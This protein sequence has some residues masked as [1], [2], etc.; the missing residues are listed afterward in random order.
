MLYLLHSGK[1]DILTDDNEAEI[2]AR[3]KSEK[4]IITIYNENMV[5]IGRELAE[6]LFNYDDI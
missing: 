3:L 1:I 2:K 5:I 6:T 4:G